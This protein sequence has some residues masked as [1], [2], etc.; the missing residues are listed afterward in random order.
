MRK[1]FIQYEPGYCG[2]DYGEEHLVPW[3]WTDHQIDAYCWAE[4]LDW[5]RQWDHSD[6]YED[7]EDYDEDQ[8]LESRVSFI[9]EDYDEDKHR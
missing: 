4:A 1:I 5:A 9:W 7:E 3:E 8:D 2:E 6:E